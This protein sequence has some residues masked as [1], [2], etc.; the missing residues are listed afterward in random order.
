[1][2]ARFMRILLMFDLPTETKLDRRNYR[3]FRKYIIESG[4]VMMQK[5]IYTKIALNPTAVKTVINNLEDNKPPDG[6]IQ[7]LTIT[8]RQYNQMLL[9]IGESPEDVINDRNDV[10]V[11]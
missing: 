8:E 3:V 1:M 2:T 10:I 7:I 11:L 4:F 6:L 9:L 5:S